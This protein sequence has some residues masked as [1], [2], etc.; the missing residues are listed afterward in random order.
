MEINFEPDW[1]YMLEKA[2]EFYSRNPYIDYNTGYTYVDYCDKHIETFLGTSTPI[3]TTITKNRYLWQTLGH[4]MGLG[5]VLSTRFEWRWEHRGPKY[6]PRG[7][8]TCIEWNLTKRKGYILDL[9]KSNKV[10]TIQPEEIW[11]CAYGEHE[12]E[13][14]IDFWNKTWNTKRTL[15]D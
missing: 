6:F 14:V 9:S 2:A 12:Y 1:D 4:N 5:K 15:D 13:K 3:L 7:A 8:N 11:F 10:L